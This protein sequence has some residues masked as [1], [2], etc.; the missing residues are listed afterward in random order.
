MFVSSLVSEKQFCLFPVLFWTRFDYFRQQG[1]IISDKK[2]RF[3]AW[4]K[5]ER[6]CWAMLVEEMRAG[7]LVAEATKDFTAI[8]QAIQNVL[9]VDAIIRR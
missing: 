8:S 9:L 5:E 2:L 6:N 4:L 7:K 3:T 1:V